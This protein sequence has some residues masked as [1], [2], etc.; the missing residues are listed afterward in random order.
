MNVAPDRALPYSLGLDGCPAKPDEDGAALVA[1]LTAVRDAA[2][3]SPVYELVDDLPTPQIDGL[4][5]D[6]FRNQ[7]AYSVRVKNVLAAARAGG[8]DALR[9]VHADLPA[10]EDVE[11]GILVDCCCPTA[12]S[13]HGTT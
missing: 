13:A 9:A 6:L 2:T 12:R 10:L 4:K 7:A 3:D 8:A 1:A 5:T 11:A